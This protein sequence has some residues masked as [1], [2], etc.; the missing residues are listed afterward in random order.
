DMMVA[1]FAILK[2][3]AAYLPLDPNYPEGRLA[4]MLQDSKPAM[5]ITQQKLLNITKGKCKQL[6]LDDP[7][8]LREI[9]KHSER[10][11]QVQNLASH[12]LAYVIYT[13]GSTGNPKGVMI[14]HRN[15]INLLSH[16]ESKAP[17]RHHFHGALWTTLN[18]DASVLEIFST[19][20]FG[21]KLYI[22]DEETRLDPYQYFDWLSAAKIN[23][24]YLPPFFIEDY[25]QWLTE[26]QAVPLERLIVGVEP[27][28]ESLLRAIESKTP[29]L[30]ILNCYGPTEATICCTGYN[31][32]QE[33]A[34]ATDRRTPIGKPLSNSR[35]YLL[36][37]NMELVPAGVVGEIYIA[38][39]GLARGYLYQ[40]ALTEQQFIQHEFENGRKERLYKTGDLARYLH[41]GNLVFLGRSDQQVKIRGFRIELG[42][43][44]HQL[45]LH[46]EVQTGV[47]LIQQDAEDKKIVAY[48]CSD[49][50]I[51]EQ[52]LINSIRLQL[53]NQLP[54]YMLPSAFMRLQQLPV[55]EN[56]KVDRKALPLVD[57]AGTT[58][59]YVAAVNETEAKL[60]EIWAELL[61]ITTEKI[62]THADFFHLGGHSL[63]TIRL[64]AQIHS[65]FNC[66]LSVRDIFESPQIAELAEKISRAE[67]S[68][69]TKIEPINRTGKQL[70]PSFAQQRLWFIDQL[71]GGSAHYN[72][73]SAIRMQGDFKLAI[74]QQAFSSIIQRHEVLRTV[75]IASTD[76]ALQVIN[77]EFDFSIHTIDLS[78]LAA[79]EQ[80]QTLITAIQSDA[81]TSFDL[82]SDL[83]LRVSYIKLA[84]DE[85]VLLF[86]MHHIASDGWSIGILVN[87]FVK[88]YQAFLAG[89]A[90]PLTPLPIQYADY[91][92]W[93]HHWL[94]GEV[95]DKQ[96]QY[97]HKQLAGLPQVHSLPLDYKRPEFQSYNGALQR[98]SID[99][100][101]LKALQNIAL[102]KQVT[103]FMLM[104]AAFAILLSRY[105]NNSDIVIGTPVAN[106]TQKELE[107]LIG[108]FVNTLVLRADCADNP[109]F[110]DF[111]KQIK[112]TN[113]DAQA[114]Q[115]VSFEQLVDK[116]NPPRSTSHNALFQILLNM[117]SNEAAEL[118]LPNVQMTGQEGKQVTAKFDLSLHVSEG[119]Q[120][121]M[122]F[123]YNTDLFSADSIAQL[124]SSM[125]CLL[126]GIARDAR[127]RI[128]QLPLL[129]ESARDYLIHDLNNTQVAYPRD[130]CI[131]ELFEQ[132]VVKTPD[133]IA[134][135]CKEQTLT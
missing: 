104:H 70:Q 29:Q 63:L 130:Y 61:K 19:I 100:E 114:N 66:E 22:V 97:W 113:L 135:V 10:C 96:L 101:T 44:E 5:V 37:N 52:T 68:N 128:M 95:L 80:Q 15:L 82:N 123:E 8:Q 78:E 89:Q 26:N 102:E 34:I 110:I 53:K 25:V 65:H 56:G 18:F 69:R 46:P 42:E 124:A 59:Q 51:E 6:V 23:C 21:G 49:S 28:K 99:K 58:D 14:E 111:L 112:N 90:N 36:G 31:L 48:F 45:L 67:S 75:F 86:N 116:L 125:K 54:E 93:Q 79:Q 76:G 3:G 47:V 98:L 106:R 24:A 83:M 122:L 81:N 117:N 121:S 127:Q 103:F 105:A 38:G 107:P 50:S 43:I 72:M 2:A 94:Q 88:L 62:S 84:E 132:Q 16:F 92:Y 64:L 12:H 41:D 33:K 17:C 40:Q 118:S 77:D 11:P 1:M 115:D 134:V 87:E 119:E 133:N 120:L 35:I 71:E 109:R 74:A 57:A 73:P 129:N 13:S 55:T 9:N 30:S 91:A 4:Y 126:T 20:L 27:I 131:H 32:N 39:D 85:G 108:F 60:V 7:Q